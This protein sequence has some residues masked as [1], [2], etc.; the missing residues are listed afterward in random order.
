MSIGPRSLPGQIALLVAVA[1][2]VAQAINFGLLLRERQNARIASGVT[3]LRRRPASVGSRGSSQPR[4][5]PP[6]TSS[7]SLRLL[8]TVYVRLSRANSVCSGSH[9]P[10]SNSTAR[11]T[12]S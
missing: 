6:S 2:F 9:G 4:T 12:Q 7:R 5:R 8:I 3:P 11:S 1:L 10:S